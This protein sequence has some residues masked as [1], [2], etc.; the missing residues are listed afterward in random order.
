MAGINTCFLKQ[1]FMLLYGPNWNGTFTKS[2]AFETVEQP[3][4]KNGLP[5][6]VFIA[7]A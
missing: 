3:H 6:K 4:F 7:G 1:V 5:A 2:K